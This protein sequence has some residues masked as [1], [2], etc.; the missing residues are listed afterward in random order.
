[1]IFGCRSTCNNL[2]QRAWA[3]RQIDAAE[4]WLY[5]A[6]YPEARNLEN[7]SKAVN[8]FLFETGLFAHSASLLPSQLNASPA[9]TLLCR[10]LPL[11]PFVIYDE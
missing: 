3:R 9:R 10:S 7:S 8:L 11:V 5:P 1:M 4:P 6:T 2:Y